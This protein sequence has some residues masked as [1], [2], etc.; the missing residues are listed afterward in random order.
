MAPE[1][2]HGNAE[3][4]S[5]SVE[6]ARPGSWVAV[7]LSTFSSRSP[8]AWQDSSCSFVLDEGMFGPAAA[9]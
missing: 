8:V 5:L 7:G 2:R 4:L 9:L 6:P 1:R 3:H